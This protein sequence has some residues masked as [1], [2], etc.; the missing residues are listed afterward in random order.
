MKISQIFQEE[1]KN[2]RIEIALIKVFLLYRIR[3]WV[4]RHTMSYHCHCKMCMWGKKV[5]VVCQK[6]KEIYS[7]KSKSASPPLQRCKQGHDILNLKFQRLRD[8]ILQI[9]ECGIGKQQAI[10]T[11][12]Y[13][14]MQKKAVTLLECTIPSPQQSHWSRMYFPPPSQSNAR[15]YCENV[16]RNK[17]K[18]TKPGQSTNRTLPEPQ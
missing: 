6:Q 2:I 18:E 5:K 17:E 14:N 10:R 12:R 11:P 9:I 16:K 13:W 3:L 7:F 1:S 4:S 8:I 15:I